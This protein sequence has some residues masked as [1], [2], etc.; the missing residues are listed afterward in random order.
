[1]NLGVLFLV[2]HTQDRGSHLNMCLDLGSYFIS[3]SP[4]DM[5]Y[6]LSVLIIMILSCLPN[7]CREGRI[8][9]IGGDNIEGLLI[10]PKQLPYKYLEVCNL[11]LHEFSVV[12]YNW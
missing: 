3:V 2:S 12:T 8:K 6:L 11:L 4:N 5:A 10:S 7:R 1:M 9:V